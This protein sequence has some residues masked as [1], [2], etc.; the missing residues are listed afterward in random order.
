[1]WHAP[2]HELNLSWN[3]IYNL[4]Q[5]KKVEFLTLKNCNNETS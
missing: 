5:H 2:K 3:N 1:M 4:L